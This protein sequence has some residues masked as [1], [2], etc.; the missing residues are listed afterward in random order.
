MLPLMQDL[1][2]QEM[3]CRTGRRKSNE[4][5]DVLEYPVIRFV[6]QNIT[7]SGRAYQVNGTLDMYGVKRIVI[8]PFSFQRISKGAVFA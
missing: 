6:S 5:L 7:R 8:I 2:I 4:W 1:S 3:D